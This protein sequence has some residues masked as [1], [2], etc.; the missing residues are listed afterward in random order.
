MNKM[1]VTLGVVVALLAQAGMV[2]AL[3][4]NEFA[5]KVQTK[6]HQTGLVMVQAEDLSNARAI[7]ARSNA[8]RLDGGEEQ[9]QLVVECVRFP[10][11]RLA[12]ADLQAY[13]D[14]MPR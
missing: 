6:S 9:V 8:K 14:A 5:C 4:S 11:G 7:A 10:Q 1:P 3:P 13:L 12:D 2:F